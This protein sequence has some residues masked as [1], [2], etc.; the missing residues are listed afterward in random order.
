MLFFFLFSKT[1][2]RSASK[3]ENNGCSAPLPVFR[4]RSCH[5]F[6]HPTLNPNWK[7]ERARKRIGFKLASLCCK[8]LNSL[9]L[10]YLSDFLRIYTPSRQLRSSSDAQYSVLPHQVL[11]ITLFLTPVSIYLEPAAI[12]Y[13]KRPFFAV[14]K[15]LPQNRSVFWS[16]GSVHKLSASPRP[17]RSSSSSCGSRQ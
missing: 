6:S 13:Q 4:I 5:T 12:H 9:D 2:F 16:S 7:R 11:W 8:S 15:G 1:S 10:Q 3:V 14:F 17:V